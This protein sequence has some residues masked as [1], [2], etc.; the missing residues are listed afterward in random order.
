MSRVMNIP[1]S[2]LRQTESRCKRFMNRQS[3]HSSNRMSVGDPTI[4]LSTDNAI[5]SWDVD[6]SRA[7][8]EPRV[9]ATQE[10]SELFWIG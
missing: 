10:N 1:E 8:A 7:C 5:L 6:L 9:A 3:S 2:N 4:G